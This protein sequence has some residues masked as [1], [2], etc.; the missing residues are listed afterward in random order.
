MLTAVALIITQACYL[1]AAWHPVDCAAIAH[2]LVKRADG[3]PE[4]VARMAFAYSLNKPTPRAARAR[5]LPQGLHPRELPRFAALVAIATAVLE[6]KLPNPCPRARHWGSRVLPNDVARAERAI[7]ARRWTAVVCKRGTA[8][9]FY[10]PA[11]GQA[12]AKRH[13]HPRSP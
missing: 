8:N 10:A 5:L 11:H 13:L 4:G 3:T 12:S 6:G 2:V 1:E 7:R 9:A